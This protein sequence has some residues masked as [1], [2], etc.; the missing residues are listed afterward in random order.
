MG[1]NFV[2][3]QVKNSL[4]VAVEN[5]WVSLLKGDDEI[6]VSAYSDAN[7][8]VQLPI[9]ATT[10]GNINLVVSK[11]DYK[12]AIHTISIIQNSQFVN[13]QDFLISD[14]NIGFS[15][16]NGDGNLNPGERIELKIV[17]KISEHPLFMASRLPFLLQMKMLR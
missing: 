13:V 3:V 4:N 1:S 14:D 2:T 16:G 17:L 8:Y 5:A 10:T 6:F 11:H 15:M 7:G 9:S 12:P